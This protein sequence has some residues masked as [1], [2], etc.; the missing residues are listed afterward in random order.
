MLPPEAEDDLPDDPDA[1]VE[2]VAAHPDR[3]EVR[4]VA[5]V[6]RDGSRHSAVRAREPEDAPLLEGPDLVP[7][8]LDHLFRTLS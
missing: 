4:L 1:L 7:G 8:L 6:T 5:A 2:A 3:R